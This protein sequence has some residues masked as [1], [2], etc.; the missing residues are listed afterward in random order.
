[1]TRLFSL[2][3]LSSFHFICQVSLL[4]EL[5]RHPTRG[6][7]RKNHTFYKNTSQL[8]GI[9]VYEIDGFENY[10]GVDSQL[11]KAWTTNKASGSTIALSLVKENVNEG[12][13]A[14]KFTYNETSDGWA[15]AT[16]SK[17][18]SWADCD[19][20]SMDVEKT[21]KLNDGNND[22]DDFRP[23]TSEAKEE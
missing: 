8:D 3:R 13:Y 10:Y 22:K 21:L 5:F 7:L 23:M 17:E 20:L 6:T 15:G 18:V 11:T 2:T 14:M 1:M 19:A 16:I 9:I 12:D 4:S